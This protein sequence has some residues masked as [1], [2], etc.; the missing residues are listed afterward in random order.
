MKSDLNELKS[1][2]S[3]MKNLSTS[4]AF[5]RMR[6]SMDNLVDADI[7]TVGDS[8]EPLVTFPDPETP[9][10][11]VGPIAPNVTMATRAVD[12]GV[13]D[14]VKFE[15]KATSSASSTKVITD[16]FSAEK[17]TS[18][19][20]EMKRLQAGDVNYQEKSAAAAMRAR[21]DIEGN[22]AEKSQ[23]HKKVNIYV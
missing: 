21:L 20:V 17:A 8:S 14:T 9:T 15:H 13:C 1:S 12:A 7:E 11:T 23:L 5:S 4:Q 2:I 18:N 22:T 19:T 3:E 16:S 10:S 6:S